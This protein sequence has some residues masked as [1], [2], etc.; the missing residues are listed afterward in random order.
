MYL[1]FFFF[2]SVFGF[3]GGNTLALLILKEIES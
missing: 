3:M 1:F 2:Y